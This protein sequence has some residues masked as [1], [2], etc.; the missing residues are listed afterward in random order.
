MLTSPVWLDQRTASLGQSR[1]ALHISE[2]H[3][4]EAAKGWFAA[5]FHLRWL[6]KLEPKN[7]E[8]QQRLAKA[9]EHLVAPN[10]LDAPKR[11]AA[12]PFAR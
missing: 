1:F 10:A 5:A 2:A 7:I 3:Q 6:A 4:A 8:W 9:L 12:V 11:E